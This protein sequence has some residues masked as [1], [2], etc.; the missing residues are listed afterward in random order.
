MWFFFCVGPGQ[1]SADDCPAG[2]HVPDAGCE[3]ASH[4]HRTQVHPLQLDGRVQ[5]VVPQ[6]HHHMPYRQPGG[7]GKTLPIRQWNNNYCTNSDWTKLAYFLYMWDIVM[8]THTYILAADTDHPGGDSSW[9]VERGGHLLWDDS[10]REGN[11]QEVQ[12][13]VHGHRWS[14][15]H[16]EWEIKG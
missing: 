2:L 3:R 9:W 1:D 5:E 11:L 10:Q 15:P 8:I 12:L 6:P 16:Q 13:E 14:S 4:C 7:K